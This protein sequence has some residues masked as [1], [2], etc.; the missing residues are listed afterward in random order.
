[1]KDIKTE[2]EIV[3]GAELESTVAEEVTTEDPAN[4]EEILEKFLKEKK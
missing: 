2:L 3:E 4:A 1:M